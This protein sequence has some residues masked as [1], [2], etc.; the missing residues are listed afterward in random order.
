MRSSRSRPAEDAP[1]WLTATPYAH[2]GLHGP[3]RLENSRAAFEAAIEAGFGIELDVQASGDGEAMVFHDYG[4]ARLTEEPGR[5]DRRTSEELRRVKL[6]GMDETIPTLC[7]GLEAI[8]GRAPV[9][10]E[11]KAPSPRVGALC[12]SVAK[13]LEGYD[14]PA[15]VMSFNPAVPRWF[16]SR[17]PEV[18]RGLVVSERERRGA[19]GPLQREIA[20]RWARPQ[21]LAYDVRDLPS[22]FAARARE[23][24]L[25]ILT[26]TVRTLEQEEAAASHADQIIHELP[27]R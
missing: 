22:P 14:R 4:L 18:V 25:P 16:S 24:G 15:A 7:E 1:G 2:R 3:G 10:I 27:P 12:R 6:I 26:W 19:S 8:G 9:L 21:F 17:A 11:V 23:R 20:Y 13:A 5:V